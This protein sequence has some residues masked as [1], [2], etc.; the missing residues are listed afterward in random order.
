MLES[1]ASTKVVVMQVVRGRK[2]SQ[3]V[4]RDAAAKFTDIITTVARGE[5]C[6]KES[7][8]ECPYTMYLLFLV[9][10]GSLKTKKK[11]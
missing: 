10:F 11:R 2:N 5:H 7:I 8:G 3:K 9:Y 1:M 6:C 4:R